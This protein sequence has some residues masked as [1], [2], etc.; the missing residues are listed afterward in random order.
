MRGHVRLNMLK[1]AMKRRH[2]R[3]CFRLKMWTEADERFVH[4]V[5]QVCGSEKQLPESGPKSLRHYELARL[6]QD[7]RAQLR[8]VRDLTVQAR[9]PG[10]SVVRVLHPRR[11]WWRSVTD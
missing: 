6:S 7:A 3:E 1:L 5:K 4:L 11:G 10:F 8:L 9:Q 2:G